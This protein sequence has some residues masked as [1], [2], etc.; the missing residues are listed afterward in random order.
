MMR[1]GDRATRNLVAAVTGIVIVLTAAIAFLL[2]S[3]NNDVD[4]ALEASKALIAVTGNVAITG[5]LGV[6]ITSTLADRD[7]QRYAREEL[8]R[9]ASG[10]L[11]DLKAAFEKA[12]VARFMLRSNPT[13]GMLFEQAPGL[14][15]ARALLQRVQRER[16][17]LGSP[18]DH[19]AQEML[20][21]IGHVL[22][23]YAAHFYELEADRAFEKANVLAVRDQPGSATPV[24]IHDPRFPSLSRFIN[25]DRLSALDQGYDKARRW[26]A[27]RLTEV[28][29][30][31][32]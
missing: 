12:Q 17:V 21:V 27:A 11:Q 7:R 1:D 19:G 10:A 30:D 4:E 8:A 29:T 3:A 5:I 15:E 20:D 2:A 31:G 22:Q 32:G 6:V 26:L 28:Q 16:S 24:L 9:L 13:G 25:D 18:A 23:E 14:L